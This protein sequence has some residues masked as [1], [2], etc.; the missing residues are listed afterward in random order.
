MIQKRFY[1]IESIDLPATKIKN[2]KLLVMQ[3]QK[4]IKISLT[5]N[6]LLKIKNNKT[7]SMI[8]KW[9][10]NFI[11]G[12]CFSLFLHTMRDK[13]YKLVQKNINL[14]SPH[15]DC[16]SWW[17]ATW[18]RDSSIFCVCWNFLPENTQNIFRDKKK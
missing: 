12:T 11:Y 13:L 5:R 18:L 1:T 3:Q 2:L 16:L 7:I 9:N 15:S 10:N 4:I 17:E 6:K 8:R 14:S